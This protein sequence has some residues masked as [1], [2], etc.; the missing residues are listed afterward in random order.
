[1]EC[2]SSSRQTRCPRRTRTA[3]AGPRVTCPRVD[4]GCRTSL[5]KYRIA[6]ISTGTL[7]RQAWNLHCVS[8]DRELTFCQLIDEFKYGGQQRVLRVVPELLLQLGNGVRPLNRLGS[9][10]MVLDELQEY[11]FQMCHALKMIGRQDLA[12][13]DAEPDFDLIQPGSVFGQPKQLDLERPVVQGLLLGQPSLQLLGGMGRSVVQDQA[14]HPYPA[15]H[16]FR[17]QHLQQES[18]EIDEAAPLTTA[19]AGLA[20]DR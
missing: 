16:G 5:S 13:Q 11:A 12:L 17:D 20:V 14:N 3:R 4:P 19:A 7:V 18:L 6:L 15:P 2:G 1:M 8:W 10:I 9:A